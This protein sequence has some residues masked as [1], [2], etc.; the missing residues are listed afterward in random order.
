MKKTSV[1]SA[2][3]PDPIKA[4]VQKA[5]DDDARSVASLVIKA[6]TEWLTAKGYL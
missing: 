2:R 6:L 5:A 3:L 4:A 1:I